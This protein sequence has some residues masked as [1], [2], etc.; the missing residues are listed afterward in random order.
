MIKVLKNGIKENG[1]YHACYYSDGELI[2][3]PKGTITVYARTYDDLPKELNPENNS[4]MRTD[5]FEKDRV[6]IVPDHPLYNE[7]K[8]QIE[9]K[10]Q[11]KVA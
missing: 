2:N 5:Y 11:R 1:K 9:Y 3:Y 7:F 6:R 4:D 8:K 10:K